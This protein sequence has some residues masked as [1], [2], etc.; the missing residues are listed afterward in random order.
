MKLKYRDLHIIKST[1][2]SLVLDLN[3]S[4]LTMSKHGSAGGDY[5]TAE[6]EGI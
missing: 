3:Q 6:E 2:D 1:D 5:G 4:T